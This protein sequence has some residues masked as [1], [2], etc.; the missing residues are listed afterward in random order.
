MAGAVANVVN[1][2]APLRSFNE[3]CWLQR[4]ISRSDRRPP[5]L[6]WADYAASHGC[7]RA[8]LMGGMIGIPYAEVGGWRLSAA[9]L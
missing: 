9:L 8:F 1:K 7:L 6:R 4:Q 5:R 2:Q 3:A